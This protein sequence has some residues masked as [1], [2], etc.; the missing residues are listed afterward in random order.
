MSNEDCGLGQAMSRLLF[1]LLLEMFYAEV[2]KSE[3]A[4]AEYSSMTPVTIASSQH[5]LSDLLQV[6]NI[7]IYF[8]V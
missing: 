6:L 3:K 4:L 1:R 2:S 7:A 5:K 8:I